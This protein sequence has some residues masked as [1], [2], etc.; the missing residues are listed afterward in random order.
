MEDNNKLEQLETLIPDL[1]KNAPK[2][3][4][5]FEGDIEQIVG[6]KSNH[7]TRKLVAQ[8]LSEQGAREVSFA[9]IIYLL[10]M[11]TDLE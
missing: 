5:G 8:G 2:M 6:S 10:L 11:N 4:E 3:M 9:S 1:I 7:V